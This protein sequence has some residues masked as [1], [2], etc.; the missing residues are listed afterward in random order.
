MLLRGDM[1]AL[2]M[3][4]DTGHDFASR[5]DGALHAYGHGAQFM[6]G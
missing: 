4:E 5:I 2:E 1:D 6:L 3:P